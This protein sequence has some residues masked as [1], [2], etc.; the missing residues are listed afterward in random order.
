MRIEALDHIVL[1]TPEPERLIDWYR[2]VLGLRPERLEQWRRGEVPFASLRV[3][4]TTI[5]DVLRGER[6]GTNLEHTAF[7]VDLDDAGLTALAA[8]HGVAGPKDLFG[9]RGQGRGIY[10]RD[11][12]GNGVE[13]RSYP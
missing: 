13:L 8:G 3:S 11:P 4:P 12:D 1:V 6:T 2:T 7:V 10:L 9:A 5:I